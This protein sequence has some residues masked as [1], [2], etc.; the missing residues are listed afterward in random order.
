MSLI[1][2]ALKKAQR[3]RS[4]RAPSKDSYDGN[5]GSFGRG[6]GP[7]F[8]LLAIGGLC[9]AIVVGAAGGLVVYA[10]TQSQEPPPDHAAPPGDTSAAKADTNAVEDAN[11]PSSEPQPTAPSAN[12]AQADK[13]EAAAS[14]PAGASAKTDSE[15][16]LAELRKAT[17]AAEAEA[18]DD[19]E[20]ATTSTADQRDAQSKAE[21][22]KII[23]WIARA[24]ITGVRPG[25]NGK[26]I[27]N[28]R[29]LNAG[30]TANYTL[31]VK[32]VAIEETRVL[33]EDESG[34]RY[35]KRF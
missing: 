6:E 30:E 10:L 18:D 7:G 8:L 27:L 12:E 1:N 26:L 17:E 14:A 29:I 19:G 34:T 28:G 24:E 16:A 5:G 35:L 32:I 21:Q 22:D 13:D 3:D 25:D 20:A 23:A 9:L 2:Q 15:A 11:T 4:A 33:F 31:G